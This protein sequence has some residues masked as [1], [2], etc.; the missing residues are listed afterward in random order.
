MLHLARKRLIVEGIAV[1]QRRAYDEMLRAIDAVRLKLVVFVYAALLSGL[2]G[3]L[4]LVSFIPYVGGF[5][6]LVIA[7]IPSQPMPN[8]YGLAPK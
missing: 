1:G 5:F 6:M 2:S 4:Y 8:H 3:W 7:C